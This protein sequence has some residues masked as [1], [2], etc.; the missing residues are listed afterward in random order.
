MSI[1]IQIRL[2][3]K[4]PSVIELRFSYRRTYIYM[5]ELIKPCTVKW[6]RNDLL[7]YWI[8]VYVLESRCEF[9]CIKYYIYIK[10]GIYLGGYML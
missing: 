2:V 8:Y 5:Q 6:N 7:G 9:I 3:K 1:A 4:F 10:N